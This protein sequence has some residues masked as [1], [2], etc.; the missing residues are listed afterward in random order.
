MLSWIA[1]N[2]YT[3]IICIVLIAIVT[4]VTVNII[5]NMRNGK[6]SCGCGCSGCPMKGSCH[7]K[8]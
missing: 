2:I 4:S 5:R 6:T 1:E 3:I 8:K 7:S